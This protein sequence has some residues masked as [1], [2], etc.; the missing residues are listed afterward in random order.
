MAGNSMRLEV[1]D[2]GTVVLPAELIQAAPHTCL[3]AERQGDVVVLRFPEPSPA[4]P[5][6]SLLDL[7]TI[8]TGPVD[9]AMT[10]RRA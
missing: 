6:R 4:K 5:A 3:E 8:P 1:N 9:P 2:S 7:P 10:L